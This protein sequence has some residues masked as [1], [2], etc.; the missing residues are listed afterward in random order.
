MF[1][2]HIVAIVVSS[3]I[4]LLMYIAYAF[5][6][7]DDIMLMIQ[8][9]IEKNFHQKVEFSNVTLSVLPSLKVEI[10]DLALYENAFKTV[11]VKKL[12]L[13]LNIDTW[14]L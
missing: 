6:S 1:K 11:E 10:D 9:Q 12:I 2:K 8:N 3:I 5:I 4:L 7:K 13:N 14:D